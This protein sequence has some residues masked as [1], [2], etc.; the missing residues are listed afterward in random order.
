M[1]YGSCYTECL[2]GDRPV[3][4]ANQS[5]VHTDVMIGGPEV[6]VDGITVD[7][8]VVPLPA[9][10][11][12][13]ALGEPVERSLARRGGGNMENVFGIEVGGA[14]AISC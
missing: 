1:A 9:A 12:L 14:A 11:R 4:G 3:D 7:G 10:R 5:N 8:T 6:D 2:E 13:A